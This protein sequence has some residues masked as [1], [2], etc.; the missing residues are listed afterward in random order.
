ML[1]RK[2]TAW[3]TNTCSNST[4]D[5]KDQR[6]VNIYYSVPSMTFEQVFV[7]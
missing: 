1:F 6:L 5:T 7:H 4:K 2:T 3:R